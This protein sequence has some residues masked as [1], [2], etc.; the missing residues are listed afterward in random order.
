MRKDDIWNEKYNSIYDIKDHFK[1]FFIQRRKIM[2]FHCMELLIKLPLLQICMI[3]K[4]W[5]FTDFYFTV[6]YTGDERSD[7]TWK[8]VNLW[9][10]GNYFTFI[11]GIPIL[12][13][14]LKIWFESQ[15]GS[16]SKIK[17][18]VKKF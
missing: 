14:E 13:T 8:Y 17:I 5:N 4:H 12:K 15:V 1:V 18:H 10:T 16:N 11:S 7:L 2:N 9:R 6:K 3:I